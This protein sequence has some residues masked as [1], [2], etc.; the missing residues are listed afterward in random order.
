VAAVNYPG[1][2]AM[3]SFDCG[4]RERAGAIVRSLRI[5]SLTPS[6]GGVTTTFSHP[7]TSSHRL[8]RQ[9]ERRRLGVGDG[10]LRISCGIE[11][12]DDVWADISDALIAS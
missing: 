11:A 3:L 4:S 9:D 6:L 7:A 1:W 5:C 12:V 10:L 2:G 8:L